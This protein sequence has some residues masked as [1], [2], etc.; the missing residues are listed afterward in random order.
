[1]RGQAYFTCMLFSSILNLCRSLFHV[2][3]HP[4]NNSDASVHGDVQHLQYTINYGRSANNVTPRSQLYSTTFPVT[5]RRKREFAGIRFSLKSDA[6]ESR[7]R[8]TRACANRNHFASLGV[9]D[10]Y[11]KTTNGMPAIGIPFHINVQ[12]SVF[13]RYEVVAIRFRPTLTPAQIAR[14]AMTMPI[15]HTL[16]ITAP[17]TP[18]KPSTHGDMNSQIPQI[19]FTHSVHA[20]RGAA[21]AQIDTINTI[22]PRIHASL[23][24]ELIAVDDI[25]MELR[26]IHG[27]INRQIPRI[28]LTQSCHRCHG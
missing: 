19:V 12:L 26:H 16:D 17:V 10:L 11:H 14:I 22:T 5:G 20:A 7:G 23:F 9:P 2:Q 3:S 28:K 21:S 25:G 27:A 1:M 24:A 4:R 8:S 18:L 15:T 6:G 13:I